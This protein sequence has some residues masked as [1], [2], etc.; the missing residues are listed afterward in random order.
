MLSTVVTA[1]TVAPLVCEDC[2]GCSRCCDGILSCSLCPH[3]EPATRMAGDEPTCEAC[4]ALVDA[5]IAVWAERERRESD[6]EAF[7]PSTASTRRILA[8]EGWS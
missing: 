2:D 7:G 6:L 8:E 4:G 3:H 1:Q 5:D